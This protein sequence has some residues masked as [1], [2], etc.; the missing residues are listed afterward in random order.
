MAEAPAKM[1]ERTFAVHASDVDVVASHLQ[2]VMGAPFARHDSAFWGPYDVFRLGGRGEVRI[3][4]N[5]DPMFSDGDPPEERF[6]EHAFRDHGVL[7][8]AY[9]TDDD[10]L[11]RLQQSLTDAFAGTLVMPRRSTVA[12]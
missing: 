3:V 8:I 9:L 1:E 5:R 7:V 11:A 4:Y 12:E 10:L 6:F 2:P